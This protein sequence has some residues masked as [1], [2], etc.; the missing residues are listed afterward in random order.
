MEEFLVPGREVVVRYQ[1]EPGL[2]H[3]RLILAKS[4]KETLLAV[5]GYPAEHDGP[6]LWVL[7]P[8]KDA[9]P[10]ELSVPPLIGL[11]GVEVDGTTTT[12]G[13]IGRRSSWGA[14][15]TFDAPLS[16]AA[17]VEA[18][19][20]CR[21]QES[22]LDVPR[23]RLR[24]K[25]PGGRGGGLRDDAGGAVAGAADVD[26]G[27]DAARA[28]LWWREGPLPVS[29][30]DRLVRAP[31]WHLEFGRPFSGVASRWARVNRDL[32]V[33]ECDDTDLILEE[34]G[35]AVAAGED[36]PAGEDGEVDARVHAVA[37]DRE[38]R[39]YRSFREATLLLSETDWEGWPIKGPRTV[40]WC[41]EFIAEGGLHPRS[42]HTKWRHAG[43]L[44]PGN[45]G[46][47]EHEL[48]MGCLE[49]GLTLDQV[50]ASELAVFELL[51][52]RAQLSELK[53][54]HKLGGRHADPDDDT[55]LYLGTG[56]ARGL[57]MTNPSLEEYV[58]G[59]LHKE[60]MVMK[61]RRKLDEER[62]LARAPPSGRGGGGGG[63]SS[64]SGG[65]SQGRGGG[66]GGKGAGRAKGDHDGG[67]PGRE[68]AQ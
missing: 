32:F 15:Y 67:Q 31:S 26:G 19:A 16:P 10:E 56:V 52:R 43:G 64:G 41:A 22:E 50:N 38:E 35:A 1:D 61:E 66:G 42:R 8:D 53:C 57:L 5:T 6:Y 46:V 63:G 60:G 2:W 68:G 65:H 58:A 13:M 39:R 3:R 25:G 62:R 14:E 29:A 17:F 34:A 28:S 40:K 37:R 54:K 33:V 4:C 48:A 49:L 51:M 24:S 55:H 23:R 11:A 59:E 12:R 27:S 18:A 7:T 45:P 21:A 9:Y 44:G 20:A 47:S 30:Q 36:A